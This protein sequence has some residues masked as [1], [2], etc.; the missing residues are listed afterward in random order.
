MPESNTGFKVTSPTVTGDEALKAAN[1][2][3]KVIGEICNGRRKPGNIPM[4]PMIALIQYARDMA[5]QG[6]PKGFQVEDLLA[7]AEALETEKR[8]VNVGNVTGVGDD[9]IDTAPARAAKFI[10]AVVASV[11]AGG[12]NG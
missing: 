7:V 12:Q 4:E 8:Y 1:E 2:L 5:T 6:L 11:G 9:L 10:R 3:E